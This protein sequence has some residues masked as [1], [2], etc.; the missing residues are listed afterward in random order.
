MLF[1]EGLSDPFQWS[2]EPGNCR[3]DDVRDVDT[4]LRLHLVSGIMLHLSSVQLS[5]L[6]E[7]LTRGCA[8]GRLGG[9]DTMRDALLEF[10]SIPSVGGTAGETQAQLWVAQTMR[11]WGWDVDVW[12]DDPHTH[13]HDPAYPGM[14]VARTQV[15]GVIGRPP[16]SAGRRLILGHTDVVPAGPAPA[17]DGDRIVGR[18]SVDMKAGLIAGMFAALE[19]GGDVAVCA[20]SGEEDGGI[21]TFLALKHGLSAQQCVIPE[22]TDLT[23]MPANAGSLTFRIT[24]P[25]VAAH[26][27]RRW[28]GHNALEGLPEVLNRLLELEESRNTEVP[29]VLKSW[30]IA[31]PISVG[32]IAGGDWPSTVMAQVVFE[33]R[34]GVR[35]DETLEEAI[36]AFDDALDGTGAHV[37]WPGGR[38]A[39]AALPLDDPLVQQVSIAHAEVTGRAPAIIGATYGSDLRQLLGAGIPTIQYGPGDAALAHSE[40]EEVPFADVLRCREVLQRWLQ[41]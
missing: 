39:S 20:V 19:A 4:P 24:L 14:E 26:G 7:A 35:L 41:M 16:G 18:G 13:A 6:P 33:G 2:A 25:G 9:V 27:A 21:G 31:Y 1:T 29:E 36:A 22:P 32:R 11:D 15:T 34:Y 37:E 17:V 28:D 40:D 12:E 38:F 23:I 10:L 30:P 8:G 3:I 5:L